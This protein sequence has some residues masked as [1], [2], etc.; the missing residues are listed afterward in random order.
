LEAVGGVINYNDMAGFR[1][2]NFYYVYIITNPE[3]TVLY[4]GVTN[5]LA[6]R[7]YEHWLNRGKWE[8]FAGRYFCY[9]LIHYEEFNEITDAIAREKQIKS[10]NR[11]RKERLIATKNPEWMFLNKRVCGDW[12]PSAGYIEKRF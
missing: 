9:N 8:S 3:R 12:P 1:N 5:N 10:W 7:L 2:R 4:T 11:R 6:Q